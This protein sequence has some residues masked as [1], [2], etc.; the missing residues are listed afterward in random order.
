M[1]NY[2]NEMESRFTIRIASKLFRKSKLNTGVH[3]DVSFRDLSPRDQDSHDV[4]T[5]LE[6]GVG[7]GQDGVETAGRGGDGAHQFSLT[8]RHTGVRVTVGRPAEET[9]TDL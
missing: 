8:Q 2:K 7:E 6:R 1:Q 5:S 9:V 4:I 3:F